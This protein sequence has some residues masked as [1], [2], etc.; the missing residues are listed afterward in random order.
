MKNV[1]LLF[2]FILA[3]CTSPIKT[4]LPSI[5]ELGIGKEIPFSPGH[6]MIVHVGA[7]DLPAKVT[8]VEIQL[9]P[10]SMGAPPHIHKNEDEIFIVL[11]GTAHFLNG[12]KEIVAKKGTIASL[13]R[14]YYHGFWNP[15]S[16]PTTLALFIAPG[17]FEKFFYA[18]EE[19]VK[20]RR[21]KSPKEF[22]AIITELAGSNDVIIDMR[23]LPS[24]GLKLLP[25]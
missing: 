4:Y 2:T 12:D 23:K 24:S 17:H 13:P 11:E 7:E 18:V 15:T 21:P 10:M 25:P 1:L 22:G 3:S 14:G 8:L 5:S 6:N 16:S 19:T 9:A 20:F